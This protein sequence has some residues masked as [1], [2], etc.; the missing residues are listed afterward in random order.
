MRTGT[1]LNP[2]PV[3]SQRK[4]RNSKPYSLPESSGYPDSTKYGQLAFGILV[5]FYGHECVI[6]ISGILG[7]ASPLVSDFHIPSPTI[8]THQYQRWPTTCFA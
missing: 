6:V 2:K 4:P 5:D 1:R 8:G 3:E 7:L